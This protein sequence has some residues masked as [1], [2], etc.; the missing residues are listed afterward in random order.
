MGKTT[1]PV[2]Y[3]VAIIFSLVVNLIL[4][5]VVIALPFALRPIL[6]NVV[7][8]LNGLENAVIE[9]TV[10]VDQAMPVRD[11]VIQVLQPITVSTTSESQ[12]EAAYV[13]MYLG[14]GSQVAGTTY[15]T[16]PPNT[17]LPI[18]FQNNIVMSSTIPVQLTIPVSIPLK[19]TQVG[20][21]AANLKG[22]LAPITSLLGIR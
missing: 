13:V 5:A 18:D 14:N 22:M 16:M 7:D 3:R 8:E 6:G 11:V 17:K 19:D 10:E 4:V 21:F 9:T 15:I 20:A 1:V 2:F 12:I